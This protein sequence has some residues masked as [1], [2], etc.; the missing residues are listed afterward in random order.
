MSDLP[1]YLIMP[2]IAAVVYAAGALFFKEA[3]RRGAGTLHTFVVTSWVMAVFFAPFILWEKGDL[4]WHLIHY[5]LI[6]GIAFFIGHWITFTAI[7]VGDVSLVMP[8]M[9]TKSVF[10]AF[11]AWIIFGI[12]IPGGMWFAALLTAIAIFILGKTDLK[13][14]RNRLPLATGLT[15]VS[16]AC[17]GLCDALVQEWAPAFGVK[18]FLSILFVTV[19]LL[20]TCLMP[21]FDKPLKQLDR[22]TLGWLLG[23]AVLTGQQAIL[24]S[25]SVSLYHN[26]TGVNVVYSSRGLWAIFLVWVTARLVGNKTEETDPRKLILRF[27]GALLMCI[28]ILL[29]VMSSS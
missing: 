4:Q 1:L 12:H 5:P 2:A 15:I 3:F 29:A 20:A 9:G 27:S 25:L 16:S 17:F 21:F 10:V 18:A 19:A 26:A 23:G 22:K 13:P 24:I 8:V 6:T 7:R 11:F 28:A 14:L